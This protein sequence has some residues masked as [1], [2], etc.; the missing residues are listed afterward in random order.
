MREIRSAYRILA[1]KPEKKRSLR[2]PRRR[3]EDNIKTDF[4]ETGLESV[5]VSSSYH[6]STHCH[7]PDHDMNLH[8]HENL[9]P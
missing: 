2:R 9:K 7:N 1:E 8:R 5:L 3:K 4:T 6:I